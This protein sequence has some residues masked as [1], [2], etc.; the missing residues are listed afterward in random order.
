MGRVSGAREGALDGEGLARWL[1]RVC[2]RSDP[3][4]RCNCFIC[5]KSNGRLEVAAWDAP[6]STGIFPPPAPRLA[7]INRPQLYVD[8]RLFEFSRR[9]RIVA[10]GREED[11]RVYRIRKPKILSS[12]LSDD[13][14]RWEW[15]SGLRWSPSGERLDVNPG[16][17]RGWR[18]GSVR[19]E[20]LSRRGM[21]VADHLR[22]GG[23]Y[24][25]KAGATGNSD[26]KKWKAEQRQEVARRLFMG[27]HRLDAIA[28]HLGLKQ[29]T[30]ERGLKDERDLRKQIQ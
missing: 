5:R 21:I 28:K 22:Q 24:I 20:P 27:Q 11:A 7:P 30:V 15:L 9:Y 23:W 18:R 17:R 3:P 14:E 1:D 25:E 10:P 16:R 13:F 29:D 19:W 26:A 2:S 8:E 4:P 12:A 6:R